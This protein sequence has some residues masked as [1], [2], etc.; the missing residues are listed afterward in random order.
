MALGIGL[1]MA[2]PRVDAAQQDTAAVNRYVV[3]SVG[4]WVAFEKDTARPPGSLSRVAKD[5]LRP[6]GPLSRVAPDTRVG[7]RSTKSI[8]TAYTLVLRDP[9]SLRTAQW[10]CKPVAQCLARRPA[11]QLTLVGPALAAS[12]RTSGLFVHLADDAEARARVRLVGARGVQD[13]L[14]LIV[15]TTDS[16]ATDSILARVTG[17]REDLVVRICP[18]A[19]D[20]GGDCGGHDPRA[21]HPTAVTVAVYRRSGQRLSGPPLATGVAIVTPR[22]AQ[23]AI[24]GLTAD[25]WRDLLAI[26]P[27]VTRDEFRGLTLAAA[28]EIARPRP[29]KR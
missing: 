3:R 19:G 27:S 1:P 2:W 23:A 15:L 25:Y 28:L 18:I 26:R 6:L 12:P 16:S 7:L 29:S 21:S 11:S 13:D 9:R 22:D 8:D 5:I 4:D 24:A 10:S 14:G 17:E 20:A